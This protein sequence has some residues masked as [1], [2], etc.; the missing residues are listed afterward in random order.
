MAEDKVQ[1]TEEDLKAFSTKLEEWGKG[2]SAK[3]R[4]LLQ[5]M[6][7]RAAGAT[8]EGAELSDEA[9]EAV[10]G[11]IDRVAGIKAQTARIFSSLVGARGGLFTGAWVE[12]GDPW[13]LQGGRVG[14][15]PVGR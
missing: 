8:P 2:L 4:A 11:G 1:I 13:I 12:G 10:S 6:I 15:G 5:V 9:L 7:Y 3:E 14:R